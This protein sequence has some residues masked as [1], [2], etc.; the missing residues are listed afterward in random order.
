MNPLISIIVPTYNVE[1]YLRQCLESVKTQVYK[2][3]EVIIVIDGATD[4]SYEIAKEFCKT[5]NRFHVYWQE[6]AGSGPARNAGLARANGEF[7]M[8]VDPDDWI[9]PE[10]LGKLVEA[11]QEGDYDFVATKRTFVYC[12]N[13][14]HIISTKPHHFEDEIIEGRD[15]VRQAYIRLLNMGAVGSPTEKLYKMS[16]IRDNKIEFP[17]LRRSQDVAFNMR[18]YNCVDSLRLLSYSGYNYRIMA[19][20]P[21]GKSGKDY[22]KTILWFYDEYKKLYQAWNLSFPKQKFCDFFFTVRLNANLQQFIAHRWDFKPVVEDTTIQQIIKTAK[23]S[24]I[25]HKIL[26]RLLLLK[27]YKLMI[28]YLRI[29]ML[30]KKRGTRR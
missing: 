13:D 21:T 26:R 25:H 28:I 23:P 24:S 9:E 27:F 1:N 18:Y 11:Q 16:I 5:D 30:L 10:L 3:I 2:N 17:S 7:V 4:G 8:F 22:Y 6:N 19:L 12:D 14:N 15:N 20:Q 29:E